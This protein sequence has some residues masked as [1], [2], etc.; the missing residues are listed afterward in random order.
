[1]PLASRK[2]GDV[3]LH[4]YE[5]PFYATIYLPEVE[6]YEIETPCIVAWDDGNEDTTLHQ[7]CLG[8]GFEKW[9]NVA[10]VSDTCDKVLEQTEASLIAAFNEDCREGRWLYRMMNDPGGGSFAT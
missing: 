6:R 7:T 2:L 5:F 3:L 8:Y 1:M 10:V 4:I 9:L